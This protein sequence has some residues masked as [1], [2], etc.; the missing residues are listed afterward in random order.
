MSFLTKLT[1]ISGALLFFTIVVVVGLALI[2]YIES[3]HD[4]TV[5]G[6][7]PRRSLT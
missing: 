1:N 4:R 3:G 6:G 5:A 7:P 2:D